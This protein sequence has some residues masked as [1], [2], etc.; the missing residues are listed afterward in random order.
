VTFWATWCGPCHGE[1][2]ALEQFA[3]SGSGA[4]LVAIDYVDDAA[5][6]RAF[7]AR[8]HWSFSVLR[9]GAGDTGRR[10]G[11]TGLPTT[12]VLD[13]TGRI[14]ATLHGPQTFASLSGAVLHARSA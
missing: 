2:P 5:A 13:R 3:R 9:D 10:F 14:V 11:V 6:A 1:A 12:Y 7:V 4:R 8:Y